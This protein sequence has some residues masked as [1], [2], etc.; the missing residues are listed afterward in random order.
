M[1][2]TVIYKT[3][4]NFIADSLLNF[5]TAQ[6]L[7]FILINFC[8][9]VFMETNILF[10]KEVPALAESAWPVACP[11]LLPAPEFYIITAFLKN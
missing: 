2:S 10:Y 1:Y 6:N 9:R 3:Q 5:D 11:L 7:N 8:K 4:H